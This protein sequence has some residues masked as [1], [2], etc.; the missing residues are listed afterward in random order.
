M[1]ES[2]F[3]GPSCETCECFFSLLK[4]L[5]TP[6]NGAASY[7]GLKVYPFGLM[8]KISSSFILSTFMGSNLA[9]AVHSWSNLISKWPSTGYNSLRCSVGP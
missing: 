3:S 9:L 2:S 5:K 6:H 8:I 4:V 7:E 1:G